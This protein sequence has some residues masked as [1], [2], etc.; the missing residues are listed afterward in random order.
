MS[1]EQKPAVLRAY[2]ELFRACMLGNTLWCL[3]YACGKSFLEGY[4]SFYIMTAVKNVSCNKNLVFPLV[5]LCTLLED[6]ELSDLKSNRIS[7]LSCKEL[8]NSMVFWLKL[9]VSA[10][11]KCREGL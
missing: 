8:T 11:S 3:S 10:G 5:T 9:D 1:D 2:V 4:F 7:M 6:N